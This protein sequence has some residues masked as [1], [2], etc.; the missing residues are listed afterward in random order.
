[1]V[2]PELRG[3]RLHRGGVVKARK[4]SKGDWIKVDGKPVQVTGIED[5]GWWGLG[6]FVEG[7]GIKYKGGSKSGMLR[8][9]K[10]SQVTHLAGK[11]PRR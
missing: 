3:L 10:D 2:E 5:T 7:V 6:G 11:P 1:M 4:V 8:R 9:G